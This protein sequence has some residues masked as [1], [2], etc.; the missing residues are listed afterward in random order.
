M[1]FTKGHKAFTGT[2]KTRFVKGH[3]PWNKGQERPEFLGVKHPNWKGGIPNCIDCGL[4]LSTYRSKRCRLH[5]A[6]FNKDK[7]RANGIKG[8]LV[9]DRT[10]EPTS[11]EKKVYEE[12]KKGG[13]LFE[14]QKVIGGKFI[15]DAYIPALNLIIEVDGS[16]WHSLDKVKNK[17]KAENAYLAKCGYKVLRIP[18]DRVSEFST[19]LLS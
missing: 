9:Q 10:R 7:L 1:G 16:Y 13:F 11:I 14:T 4:K 12:L 19:A 8:Y 5:S 6:N 3:K 2:E 15:V 18:E 17:D